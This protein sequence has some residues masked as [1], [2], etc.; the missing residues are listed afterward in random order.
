MELSVWTN[1]REVA[2]RIAR[3]PENQWVYG[4]P[5]SSVIMA[6]FL[7]VAPDGMRFN[8]AE[9]GA[10]YAA[11]AVETAIAEV[12]H[13]LRREAIARGEISM[14]RKYRSYSAEL[15]GS[16]FHDI[17]GLQS[18]QPDLYRSDSYRS[19]EHTSEL[20]SLMLL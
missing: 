9:L 16:D 5:N 19:E 1:Y 8:R 7:H 6:S 12:A 10:W 15:L 11:K 17:C 2:D 20:Q 14:S 18:S 4:R 3:L 13:H